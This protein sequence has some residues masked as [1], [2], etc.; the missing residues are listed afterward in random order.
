MEKETSMKVIDMHCDTISA[1]YSSRRSGSKGGASLDSNHLHID[2]NKMKRGNYLAQNFA[3]FIN[4]KADEDP[5]ESCLK[6]VDLYY[7]EIRKN[8][9]EIMPALRAEDIIK[10]E[11]E[12][13]MSSLLTIEE[14]GV[15]K[16]NLANLRNFYRLGVRMLTLTWN[17]ENEIAY[18]S[19]YWNKSSI[20]A[21]LPSREGLKNFGIDFISE[22]NRLGMIIDVSHLSD[23][24]IEDV[25]KHSKQPFV[26]S[27]SNGRRLC[28]HPRNLPDKL[29]KE[30]SNMGCVIGINFYPAFLEDHLSDDGRNSGTISSIVSHINHIINVAGSDCIGLGSDFDGMSGHGQL[31]D[32]SD[33][34]KLAQALEEGKVPHKTIEKIFY[35]NVF[36]LYKEVLI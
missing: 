30:M 26:A 19:S 23:D 28:N 18:P 15:A 3:L 4:L 32:A 16:G 8:K 31:K 7:Q 17:Y 5:L 10:N 25:L 35:K 34:P 33:L 13:K 21:P 12:G 6:M 20:K 11:E 9:D 14:G 2:I 1:L 36:N 22:M 24:G 29:I 27:H